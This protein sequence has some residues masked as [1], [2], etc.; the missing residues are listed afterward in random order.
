MS[1]RERT[2]VRDLRYSRWHRE[3][4]VR[5]YL[6]AREAWSLGYI[7][8][9]DC[10][11]CRHCKVPLALIETQ[12][13]D[14]QP[15]AAPVTARLAW[16]AGIPAYSVSVVPGDVE[17]I[18]LFRVQ[19]IAPTRGSVEPMLPGAYARLLRGFRDRHLCEPSAPTELTEDRPRTG[20]VR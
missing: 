11:F 2:G 13:S 10:E 12:V 6:T 16:L 1:S 3:D 5:R 17:E 8:I 14:G 15:K 9:D 18:A 19:Q 7:D 20:A 4:S